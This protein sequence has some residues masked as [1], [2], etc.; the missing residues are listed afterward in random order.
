MTLVALGQVPRYSSTQAPFIWRSHTIQ[1]TN[2]ILN[3]AGLISVET[4]DHAE[5]DCCNF[6][7][8]CHCHENEFLHI[9]LVVLTFVIRL[10]KKR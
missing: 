6:Q 5:S 2:I 10:N 8:G 4:I 7:S 3:Q 9:S 1:M